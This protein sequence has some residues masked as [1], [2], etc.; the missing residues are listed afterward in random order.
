MNIPEEEQSMDD[1]EDSD[2]NDGDEDEEISHCDSLGSLADDEED[3]VIMDEE[4]TALTDDASRP[5]RIPQEEHSMNVAVESEEKFDSDGDSVLLIFQVLI[6]RL[7]S[8]KRKICPHWLA[9]KRRSI[10]KNM[11]SSSVKLWAALNLQKLT[12]LLP[13]GLCISRSKQR[14]LSRLKIREPANILVTESGF[15]IA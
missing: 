10:R 6:I 14:V 3:S 9:C 13:K 1:G 11:D 12:L 2:Y 4:L 8:Q 7:V 15:Q 5:L